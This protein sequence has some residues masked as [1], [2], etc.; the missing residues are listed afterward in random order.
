[1]VVRQKQL[2]LLNQ[3]INQKYKKLIMNKL[4]ILEM[5]KIVQLM[6]IYEQAKPTWIASPSQ[7]ITRLNGI[8][9]S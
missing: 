8:V 5:F 4:N 2:T 7:L 3:F 1:M 6:F 9:N